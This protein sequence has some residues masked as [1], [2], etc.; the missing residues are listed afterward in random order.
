MERVS[1]TTCSSPLYSWPNCSPTVGS[2]VAL[3]AVLEA[4]R[5]RLDEARADVFNYI[6]QFYNPRRRHSRLGYLS[7]AE[8]RLQ[9]GLGEVYGSLQGAIWSE[10]SRGG[11]IDALRR[12]LQR[13]HLRRLQ[14]LLTRGGGGLPAEAGA[15]LRHH[16]Q[17]LE[18]Q[19]V[20]ASARGGLSVETRA[21][22]AD[23]LSTLR[24]ALRATMQRA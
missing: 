12:A 5:S 17:G 15:L 7:P 1:P 22:L 6:E 10:L 16:A 9:P 19:L 23:S 14:A 20:Q 3:P 21:H 4:V 13:E 11:E 24:A 8:R 2:G 18:R